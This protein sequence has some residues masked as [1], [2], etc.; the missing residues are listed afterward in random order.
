AVNGGSANITAMLVGKSGSQTVTVTSASLVSIDVTPANPSAAKGTTKQFTATGVFSDASTQNLTAMAT[1]SS[2]AT[3]VATVSIS[4]LASGVAMGSANISASYGGQ[5]GQTTFTVT[6]ATLVSIDITPKNPTKPLGLSEQLTAT[7]T[8]TDATTQDLTSL[9]TWS[10]DDTSVA[11]V[12][13]AGG[14]QGKATTGSKT[15]TAKIKAALSGVEAEVDFTT[16]SPELVSIGV[17]PSN[18]SIAK[19]LTQQFTATGVYTDNSSADITSDVT[20]SSSA[21]DVASISNAGGSKGLASS[22]KAG[23]TTV[24]AAKGSINGSTTLTVT[25][26]ELV[27]V[28][29]TP[30]TPSI[31]KGLT[32]QFALTG[33]YTDATTQDLTAT[34]TWT[35]SNTGVATI[36]NAGGSQG[37]A[38][39]V[40]AGSTTITG[41]SGGKSHT[42]TLTV[43]AA[44]L[45]SVGVTPK[46]TSIA[47]GLTKQFAVTGVYTD[48]ST[49]DL[50]ASATWSSSDTGVATISNAGGSQGLATSAGTGSTTIT[51]TYSGQSD[52]ASLAV[53]A[54]ELVSIGVSGSKASIPK[55]LTTQLTATGTYTDGSKQALTT[56]ATWTSNDSLVA[57]V[58][59]AG[60]KGL[61]SGAGK[62]SAT[63]TAAVGGISGTFDI[64]VTDAELVSIA[65]SPSSASVAK[66]LTQQFAATGTYTDSSTQT[67]T[68]TV[69]W[70]SSDTGVV[71]ISNA[72]GSKGLASSIA[73][74]SVTITATSGTVS[75]TASMTVTAATLV[76]VAVT[77]GSATKAAGYTQ[78]FT[79][80]GTY[81]DASTQNLTSS[82]TWSSS[83]SGVG[84]VSNAAGTKGLATA[85]SSG[86]VT[87]TALSGGVS[88]TAT[89]TVTAAVVTSLI[90]T[91]EI[92]LA[93]GDAEEAFAMALYSNSTSADVTAETTWTSSDESIV[94]LDSKAPN[95]A[96]CVAEGNAKLTAEYS[97]FTAEVPVN[98]VDMSGGGGGGDTKK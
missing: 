30:G 78:Q 7:G 60:S 2:S 47:L 73:T 89:F 75:G 62:G 77:P 95:Q 88:G 36:S 28:A 15:G 8:Y 37:L 69:T 16:T 52:T 61:V 96:T 83:S 14:T 34:G 17:T 68:T 25:A 43:T 91:D 1:W 81:T 46:S 55:G 26:A 29:V 5:T 22:I 53:T 79:A 84:S 85:V 76:S 59:N 72:G 33:T 50:T 94:Q 97:G 24:T 54:A 65:V 12:S 32:Q 82:A 40:A 57:A 39:S 87:I 18:P 27:S 93:V 9:V 19:G 58:N 56:T 74:G 80:T 20:W 41:T 70:S 51:A 13:N 42:A 90:A 49:Q 48:A 23:S 64:S 44:T 10:S 71:T 4:G 98:C 63:I 6:A 11:T 66:G 86:T 67:L 35:S 38:T 3:G 92:N 21:S 45:V 31:A